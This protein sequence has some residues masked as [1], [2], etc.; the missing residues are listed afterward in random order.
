LGVC[1]DQLVKHQANTWWV[2]IGVET[3]LFPY[4][5]QLHYEDVIGYNATKH[6]GI[7]FNIGT[8]QIIHAATYTPFF[9]PETMGGPVSAGDVIGV[10][11]DMRH[12]KKNNN[13]SS[14]EFFRNRKSIGVV[15][16]QLEGDLFFPTISLVNGQRVSIRYWNGSTKTPPQQSV[17]AY[18]DEECDVTSDMFKGNEFQYQVYARKMHRKSIRQ[19]FVKRLS[20]RSPKLSPLNT[21]N[22]P[23]TPLQHLQVGTPTTPTRKRD[24]I[25]M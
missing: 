1:V 9:D 24:C 23:N 10:K 15:K 21:P 14:I 16:K 6:K 11:F 20:L 12:S 17:F 18:E 19:A 22:T 13:T 5:T 2:L 7:G 8:G 3:P 4:A 25:V